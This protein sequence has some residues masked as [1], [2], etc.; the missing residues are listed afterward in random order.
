MNL[1]KETTMHASNSLITSRAAQALLSCSRTT[2]FRLSRAG[3]LNPV[4]LGRAVR[5]KLSELEALAAAGT[6]PKA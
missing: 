5:Y 2:L 6:T 4:K 3:H 1:L